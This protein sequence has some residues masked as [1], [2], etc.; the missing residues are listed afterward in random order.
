MTSG[1]VDEGGARPWQAQVA[2]SARDPLLYSPGTRTS[3][4]NTN[5]NL[6]GELIEQWTGQKY[7][8]FLQDRVL[9]PLGMSATEELGRSARVADQAVG[10][11][12]PRRGKWPKA[13][14]Q[15]GLAMYAS[16]GMVSTAQDMAAYMTALLSDRLLDP[17]SY[18][19]MWTP[20][21]VPQYGAEPPSD[22]SRGLGWDHVITSGNGIAEVTKAGEVPGFTSQ[23]ILYPSSDSGVFVSINTDVTGGPDP[24]GAVAYNVAES[25]YAAARAGPLRRR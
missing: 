12:A 16:A 11:K 17:A 9:G 15:N 4:S 8:T 6:L 5:Y 10:Y 1:I 19:L 23:L 20:T 7:G 13:A 25:V 14:I 24:S 2:A 21:T 18:A 3:Y 22:A